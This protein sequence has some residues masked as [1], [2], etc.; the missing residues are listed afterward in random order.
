LATYKKQL[1][2]VSSNNKEINQIQENVEQA[3]T[4]I[5][6]SQIVDGVIIKNKQIESGKVNLIAHKL[7]REPLGYI[8]IRKRAD[9]RIWD[10]QDTNKNKKTTLALQCS[11]TVHVDI[12][13]F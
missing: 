5:I 11:T 2:K 8:I 1:K 3:L 4:P 9:S 7:G 6:A 10:T 12:W 13:V